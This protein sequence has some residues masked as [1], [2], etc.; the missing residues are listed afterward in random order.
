MD[1]E[2]RIFVVDDDP[3]VLRSVERLLRTN[4][5]HVETFASTEAFLQREL[6]HGPACLILDLFMPGVNGLDFQDRLRHDLPTLPIVFLSGQADVPSTARA[7]KHGAVDFLVKPVDEP[8][9]LEAVSRA[10]AR[11][12]EWHAKQI[13]DEDTAVRL[14]RLTPREYEVCELVSRG[15]LNKQIASELGASEKTIKVHRGR[16]MRKLQVGSVADLVHLLSRRGR[17]HSQTSN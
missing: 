1:Q 9:L 13:A 11:A 15:L 2:P 4:G 16:V 17:S 8:Q 5:Y 6:E 7:M 12:L 10:C 3:S 14:A